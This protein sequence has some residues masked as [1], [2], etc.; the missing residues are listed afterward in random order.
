MQGK[1]TDEALPIYRAATTL[2]AHSRPHLGFADEGRT[3]D[4]LGFH[5]L[6]IGA[7]LAVSHGAPRL[8]AV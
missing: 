5:R 7:H 8:L 4:V 2:A 3:F 1:P 6:A